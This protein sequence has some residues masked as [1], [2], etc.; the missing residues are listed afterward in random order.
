[1]RTATI[2][3]IGALLA[4][5]AAGHAKGVI[6]QWDQYPDGA[7]I[8][9]KIGFT[10]MAPPVRGRRPLVTFRSASGRIVRVRA[11][12][13]DLNGIAYVGTEAPEGAAVNDVRTLAQEVRGKIDNARSL[14]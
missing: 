14:Q 11:S 6:V 4:L 8:G 7:A 10:I 2:L 3:S 12:E 13:A 1:M 9:Q 5:P